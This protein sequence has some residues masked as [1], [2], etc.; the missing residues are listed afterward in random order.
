MVP[1]P[2]TPP[3][4]GPVP[5]TL[6]ESNGG[7]SGATFKTQP[8]P[9]GSIPL[10]RP[11]T[12]SAKVGDVAPD[13]VSETVPREVGQPVKA[14]PGTDP[15]APGQPDPYAIIDPQAP[16]VSYTCVVPKKPLSAYAPTTT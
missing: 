2:V 5:Y 13:I 14:R 3:K 10:P 8:P 7:S 12:T 4:P 15:L 11:K 9:N 16:L 6:N 1:V